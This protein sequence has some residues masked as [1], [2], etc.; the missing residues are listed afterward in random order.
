MGCSRPTS[1]VGDTSHRA[2]STASESDSVSDPAA[3][4][5]ASQAEAQQPSPSNEYAEGTGG[6]DPS[7]ALAGTGPASSETHIADEN[8][9]TGSERP[10]NSFRNS[11]AA[12]NSR[13]PKAP[14]PR[15]EEP[16]SAFEFAA[17]RKSD[18]ARHAKAGDKAAAYETALKGW[19]ALQDHVAEADCGKL[20][21][22][23]LADLEEYGEALGGEALGADGHPILGK[24]L[25]IK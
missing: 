3:A 22:E 25:K 16:K 6:G 12:G 17:A 23:L 13:Q 19:N 1:P 11:G 14:G 15:F 24:P 2:D 4:D 10:P 20:S 18:A 21:T 5:E 9:S 8:N 7:T